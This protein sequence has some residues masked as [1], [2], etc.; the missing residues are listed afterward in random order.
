MRTRDQ[1]PIFEPAT[2]LPEIVHLDRSAFKRHIHFRMPS[3]VSC[4]NDFYPSSP[5]LG[6]VLFGLFLVIKEYRQLADSNHPEDPPEV[7]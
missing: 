4:Q 1:S 6:K 5:R 2:T 3:R 7:L